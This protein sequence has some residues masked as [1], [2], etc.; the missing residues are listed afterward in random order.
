MAFKAGISSRVLLDY[1]NL[2]AFS[3]SV[4]MD[5]SVDMLDVTVL[6]NTAKAFIPGQD[7]SS[8]SADVIFDTDTTAGGLHAALTGWKGS[9]AKALTYAPSGLVT[10]SEVFLVGA[11]Q[12]QLGASSDVAGTADASVNALTD[13][14][15]DAGVMLEDLTAITATGNGTARDLTAQS[16]NGGVAHLHVTLYSGLT[17]NIVTIEDSADGSTGWATIATFTTVTGV[18]SQRLAISGTVKRHL[19]VVDTA[20]GVGSTT[21]AVAFARR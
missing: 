15:A 2:S 5:A 10:G 14:A 9:A 1:A 18:T 11:L 3:R 16:T 20:T 8:F 21:R 7:S 6:T 4:S 17:S 13:G 19:R 12:T